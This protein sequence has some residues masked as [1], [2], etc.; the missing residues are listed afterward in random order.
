MK[1]DPAKGSRATSMRA[2]K[3][4]HPCSDFTA[5]PDTGFPISFGGRFGY[6]GAVR[7]KREPSEGGR[8][9]ADFERD[10][11]EK[12]TQ[13]CKV[14]PSV[15]SCS[16]GGNGAAKGSGRQGGLPVAEENR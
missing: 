16:A 2:G 7:L 1:F 9:Q 8:G 15:E 14:E 10:R 13:I 6:K 5:P 11:F 3:K 4:R 12:R